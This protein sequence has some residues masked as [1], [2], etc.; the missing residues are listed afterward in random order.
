MSARSPSRLRKL[1]AASLL[2]VVCLPVGLSR[3][4]GDGAINEEARA[5]FKNGVELISDARNPNYQD[6]YYQF[7]L[8]Y[9]KSHRSWKVLGNLA[10]CALKLERDGEAIEYYARY[11]EQGGAD[12]G[13]D[14]RK[15]I[16][17]DLLFLRGN[18]VT[19]TLSSDVADLQVIDA[20]ASTPAPP[21]SYALAGGKATLSLRAGSHVIVARNNGKEQR[22]E[23]ALTPGQSAE[24]QFRFGAA[25]TEARVVAS[26]P[27]P[28]ETDAPKPASSGKMRTAGL[29][30]AGAGGVMLVAGAV[31]G[32]M[33]KSALS[34][35]RDQC[36]GSK[37]PESSR[38]DFDRAKSLA[39]ITNV[40]F[41]GGGVAAAAG[42]T[43]FVV[44]PPKGAA[45]PAVGLSPA[46]GGV[47][48]HGSF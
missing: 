38:S 47:I 19:V 29:V 23:V 9:E 12:V 3:A 39:T 34:T 32:L 15:P 25:P 46:A 40:L 30:V 36:R 24:H 44:S 13:P 8:A 17:R 6:A 31:T 2:A 4:E 33:S 43:L 1:V 20:R 11:L 45:G 18:L 48:A 37:C 21:Q 42:V 27:P 10:L 16:E 35:A 26:A 7:K 14:E 41:V 22:W 28:V 5:Y